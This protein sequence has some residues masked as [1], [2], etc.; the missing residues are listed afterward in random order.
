[1]ADSIRQLIITALDTRLK[2][3]LVSGGYATNLGWNVFEWRSTDLQES[4]LPALIYR[5][6]SS[7]EALA[8][9][10]MGASSKREYPLDVEI[11]VKGADG[12]TTP[13][14]MRSM[15]ADVIKAI[16]TDPTFGGLA[17]MTEYNGDE[18][19]VLQ[20]DKIMGSTLMRFRII[21]R[22]KIWN[23]YE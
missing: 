1:M 4:E 20:E 5:D 19:S 3:I 8:I 17:D 11:E 23:P 14:Q 22:T 21:Y 16:G 12:S 13:A 2:T 18:T 9:T 10:I 15:I 7:G 6:I